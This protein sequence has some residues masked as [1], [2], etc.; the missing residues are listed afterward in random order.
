M[1][2]DRSLIV[3]VRTAVFSLVVKSYPHC[4][5]P[6]RC[7]CSSVHFSAA[8]Q[9][10]VPRHLSNIAWMGQKFVQLDD[11]FTSLSLTGSSRLRPRGVLGG[12]CPPAVEAGSVMLEYLVHAFFTSQVRPSD[13]PAALLVS[14]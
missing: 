2:Y 6:C 5:I 3:L 10:C 9:A 7:R 13:H 8:S 12:F 14:D 4:H 1:K 11:G